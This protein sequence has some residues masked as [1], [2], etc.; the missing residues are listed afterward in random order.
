LEAAGTGHGVVV[1]RVGVVKRGLGSKGSGMDGV[2]ADDGS[3]L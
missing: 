1:R 3:F 2:A